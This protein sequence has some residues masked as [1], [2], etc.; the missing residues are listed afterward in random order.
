MPEPATLA[1]VI[2]AYKEGLTHGVEHFRHDLAKLRTG[3]ASS[4]MFEDL[5]VDVYGTPTPVKHVGT[6]TVVDTQ[7]VTIQ[8]WDQTLLSK[9]EK[10]VTT[11]DL[12]LTA[13]VDGRSVRVPIPRPTVERRREFVK[14][15]KK[16]LE[17]A[18][19]ALRNLRHKAIEAAKKLEKDK[20]ATQ[21]ELKRAEGDIQKLLDQH[22]KALDD[23]FAAKEKEI[24][25]D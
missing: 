18:K 8:P 24:M 6:V 19:V 9:I 5:K 23:A 11:S 7:T 1:Q 22:V 10:A 13:V 16:G 25:G 4:Q 12:G 3:R 2:T 20:L 21:D 14:I 15:A 17:D